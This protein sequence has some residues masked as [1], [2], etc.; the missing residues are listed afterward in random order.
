MTH[1]LRIPQIDLATLLAEQ[2]AQIDL[3]LE[4]YESSTRN[5][6]KAVANTKSRCCYY[7]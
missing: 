5:F 7:L 4:V 1:V 6:L 3:K 2:N